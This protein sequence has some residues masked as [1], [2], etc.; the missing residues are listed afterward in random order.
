M[1]QISILPFYDVFNN[2]HNVE[3]ISCV[4]DSRWLIAT[5]YCC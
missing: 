5:E 3:M 4:T 1:I 2:E